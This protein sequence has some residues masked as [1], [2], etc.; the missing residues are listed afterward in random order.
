MYQ[1]PASIYEREVKLVVMQRRRRT[2]HSGVSLS[3][4]STN[5]SF[6]RTCKTAKLT[7]NIHI[8]LLR[9]LISEATKFRSTSHRTA[10]K[11]FQSPRVS[12]CTECVSKTVGF[13]HHSSWMKCS[14]FG[15]P[16]MLKVNQ[17]TCTC[18][19]SRL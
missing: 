6:L 4:S 19:E 14:T 2:Y 3:K 9:V 18:I 17:A 12:S 15:C 8:G 11:V 1:D 13:S 16:H 10:L 5:S 7:D